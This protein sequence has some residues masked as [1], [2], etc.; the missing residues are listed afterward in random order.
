[1]EYIGGDSAG[2]KGNRIIKPLSSLHYFSK[3]DHTTRKEVHTGRMQV[4]IKPMKTLPSENETINDVDK[5]DA[6]SPDKGNRS[7]WERSHNK[8]EREREEMMWQ[9]KRLFR[10]HLK[11]SKNRERDSKYN[12]M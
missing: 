7:K 4:R 3:K 2:M 8:K 10:D 11:N 9:S 12:Y 1:V 5:S 6:S